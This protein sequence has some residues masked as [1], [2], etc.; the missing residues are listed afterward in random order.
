MYFIGYFGLADS[1]LCSSLVMSTK[2]GDYTTG[3][4]STTYLFS[5]S[6]PCHKLLCFEPVNR[7]QVL[8]LILQLSLVDY[9]PGTHDLKTSS[10]HYFE[11]EELKVSAQ[12]VSINQI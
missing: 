4:L 8:F 9:D 2:A 1:Q 12:Q 5:Y 11:E 10:L 7:I 6:S 3:E